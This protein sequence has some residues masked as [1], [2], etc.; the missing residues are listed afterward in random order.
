MLV[1]GRGP[2]VSLLLNNGADF[3]KK[4][5]MGMT[6]FEMCMCPKIRKIFE[7]RGYTADKFHTNN[8]GRDS[9]SSVILPNARC[10]YIERFLSRC[11]DKK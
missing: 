2:F 11:K 7:S 10:D 8:Y 3:R 5:Y 4:N 9:L 1:I 6:P